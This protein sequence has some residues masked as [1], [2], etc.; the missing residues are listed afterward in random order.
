MYRPG[1]T[2]VQ[3]S[4]VSWSVTCTPQP[5]SEGI[6]KPMEKNE[7]QTFSRKGL[8][9]LAIF[10]A[11]AVAAASA[12]AMWSGRRRTGS[13]VRSQPMDPQLIQL[14]E[15]T[16]DALMADEVVSRCGIDVGA[17][18][19][20]VIE[21]SGQVGTAEELRRAVAV[22]QKVNGVH[23]VLNR[24]TIGVE[25][26]R[27]RGTRERYTNG[28]SALHESHWYGVGVGTGRRRQG[29]STDPK[30]RDDR[31]DML[32]DAFEAD[33]EDTAFDGAA[34]NLGSQDGGSERSNM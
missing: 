30:L 25:E 21:L 3:E 7:M 11:G 27:I 14:E 32:T 33:A 20:G 22:A 26:S 16:V 5:V 31:V 28:D 4:R 8:G 2:I 18:G 1:L 34:L 12:A 23:T 29:R 24:L 15:D 13:P 19:P 9:A 6:I 10:A 17:V